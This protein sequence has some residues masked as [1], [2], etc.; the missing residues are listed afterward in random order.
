M[1]RICY[2]RQYITT[3]SHDVFGLG[4]MAILFSLPW[5]LLLRL[6]IFLLIKHYTPVRFNGKLLTVDRWSSILL[7][8]YSRASLSRTSGNTCCG[9]GCIHRYG[10]PH[11]RVA[12]SDHSSIYR[13]GGGGVVMV[14]HGAVVACVSYIVQTPRRICGRLLSYVVDT[15]LPVLVA[16]KVLAHVSSREGGNGV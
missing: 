9:S 1:A 4:S 7:P 10:S 14:W 8:Y 13:F 5:T 3:A 12:H 15:P 16:Q 11:D 2:S 6:Y